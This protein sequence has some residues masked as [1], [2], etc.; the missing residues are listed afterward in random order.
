M[1]TSNFQRFFFENFSQFFSPTKR[2]T[3]TIVTNETT[4]LAANDDDDRYHRNDDSRRL[5]TTLDD[6]DVKFS[7]IFSQ[8][9][10]QNF[11]QN[12]LPTTTI[13]VV[14]RCR[15]SLS[16][17]PVTNRHGSCENCVKKRIRRRLFFCESIETNDRCS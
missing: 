10:L 6:D 14:D 7:K 15:R 5:S 4:I 3:M 9:F 13:V 2:T 11:S 8:N 17:M 16:S 1:T 12:F